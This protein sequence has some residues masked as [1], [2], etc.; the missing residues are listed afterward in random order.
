[1]GDLMPDAHVKGFVLSSF[2]A[3]ICK[4]DSAVKSAVSSKF[5]LMLQRYTVFLNDKAV[6]ISRNSNMPISQDGDTTVQ[7]TDIQSLE[8]HYRCFF[9]SPGP[10][11]L[12]IISGTDFEK[13][14]SEF[15]SLFKKINAAGGIVKNNKG[16]YL[17]I[18]RLGLWDLPKGKL[19]KKESSRDGAIREVGEETGLTDLIIT[20]Q[21]W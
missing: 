8:Y 11:N 15:N 18:K 5:F 13:A 9:A 16:E 10:G 12:N 4:S 2:I 6:I 1:M 20:K 14:C 3:L 17:F 7:Y 21:F 19:H